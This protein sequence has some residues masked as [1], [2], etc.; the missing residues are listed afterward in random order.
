M[1][2]RKLKDLA[3]EPLTALSAMAGAAL[4]ALTLSASEAPG[5]ASAAAVA[6]Q[7]PDPGAAELRAGAGPRLQ[8]FALPDLEALAHDAADCALAEVRDL[9]EGQRLFFLQRGA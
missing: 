2:R 7:A 3:Q 8:L 1:S 4:L 5:V 9:T 6:A